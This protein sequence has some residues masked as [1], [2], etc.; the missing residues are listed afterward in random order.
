LALEVEKNGY[1]H[2]KNNYQ[3]GW[4]EP[5]K[6]VFKTPKGLNKKVVC[7]ISD[8]KYEPNG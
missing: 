2:T 7:L 8:Y 6:A 5:E 3:Y 4:H 1:E